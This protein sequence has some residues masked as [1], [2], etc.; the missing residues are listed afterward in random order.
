MNAFLEQHYRVILAVILIIAL[1]H[2]IVAVMGGPL[3]FGL[4]L[5]LLAG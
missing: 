3:Y 2:G 5:A 1:A 4:V